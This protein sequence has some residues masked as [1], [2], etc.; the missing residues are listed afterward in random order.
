MKDN[1]MAILETYAMDGG[2]NIQHGGFAQLAT[3]T[4]NNVS[5]ITVEDKEILHNMGWMQREPHTWQME[6]WD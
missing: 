4:V 3:L 5:I 1:G 6:W 2:L